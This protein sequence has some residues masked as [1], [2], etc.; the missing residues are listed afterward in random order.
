M[1]K[2]L[3]TSLVLLIFP[4]SSSAD[5]SGRVVAVIEGDTLEVLSNQRPER[6]RL[7]GI[8]CPEKGYAYGKR[9]KQA[10]SE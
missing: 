1:E 5:F 10:A 2:G 8:D 4:Y 9:D 7:S 3:L 6:I